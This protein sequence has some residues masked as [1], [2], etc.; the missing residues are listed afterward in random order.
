VL[1]RLEVFRRSRGIKS[2][3]LAEESGYHRSHI[4]RIRKAEI[5]PSRDAIARIVS[6]L[7]RLSLEDVRPE[8][9]FELTAEES[10]P[11][12]KQSKDVFAQEVARFRAERERAQRTLAQIVR[13]RRDEWP[14]RLRQIDGGFSSSVARA[15]VLEGQRWIDNKPAHAE[16]LFWLAS[17][18]ADDAPDL[19]P[20]Y[21]AFLSGRARVDR[22]DA[23]RQIGNYRD[24]LPVIEE[25]ERRFEGVPSCTHELGR[26]WFWRG[27]IL[28]KMNG[29]DQA[30]R[31]V[32]LAVNIFAAVGDQRRVA[33]ARLLEGNVLYEQGQIAAARN[34]WL[35]IEP[36]FAAARDRHTLASLWLNLGWCELET[37]DLVAAG[38]WLRRALE[39]FTHLNSET[40]VARTR[41][42]MAVAEARYGDRAAGIRA[43]RQE[44]ARLATLGV[45]TE[46]AM[47]GLDL[48]ETL[49]LDPEN[50]ADAAAVC[51]ELPPLFERA[52]AKKEALRALAYLW[53]AANAGAANAELVR[54]I[55]KELQQADRD[56]NYAFDRAAVVGVAH[57]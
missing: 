54:T 32:R 57:P 40:D 31:Y 9:V 19:S 35:S 13:Q 5:E 53:E 7:R 3:D 24:A 22:A 21:R 29:L 1:T 38:E 52:G 46:A 34:L 42:A 20:D 47:V 30:L 39:R 50:S 43:L 33:R 45:K 28:F 48:A 15:A 4:L 23:L 49:L 18:V 41:W 25:A 12:Q 37:G 2:A 51:R 17:I 27:G 6:A 16:A 55:R 56:P 14:E 26:A 8:M 44:Q 10:G 36:V 11:W